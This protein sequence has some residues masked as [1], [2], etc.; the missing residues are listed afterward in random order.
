MKHH[1]TDLSIVSF[2][3]IL[4][5]LARDAT[6]ERHNWPPGGNTR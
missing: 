3:T 6:L 4:V 2:V 1:G 5:A